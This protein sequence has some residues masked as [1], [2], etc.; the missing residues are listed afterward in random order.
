MH[1]CESLR[2]NK[3]AL[4]VADV[5]TTAQVNEKRSAGKRRPFRKTMS[6]QATLIITPVLLSLL[7]LLTPVSTSRSRR[8]GRGQH[9]HSS[10]HENRARRQTLLDNTL[11]RNPVLTSSS[12]PDTLQDA[13]KRTQPQSRDCPTQ[14]KCSLGKYV[15]CTFRSL[16][17]IPNNIAPSVRKLNIAYNRLATIKLGAFTEYSRSLRYLFL[18]SN[19]LKMVQGA[20]AN[21]TRLEILRLSHNK[22]ISVRKLLLSDMVS[23]KRLYLDNNKINFIHPEALRGLTKLSLLQ[24]DGNQLSHLHPDTFVTVKFDHYFRYSNLQRLYL[25]NNQFKVLPRSLLSGINN[26][27]QVYLHGNPW[28]C[29]C[30]LQWL[31]QW[32]RESGK[33]RCKVT[34]RGAVGPICAQCASPV[35]L[36]GQEVTSVSHDNITCSAPRF[37]GGNV[38]QSSTELFDDHPTLMEIENEE[39][40]FTLGSRPKPTMSLRLDGR[41]GSLVLMRCS[42]TSNPTTSVVQQTEEEDT[43]V[44][45]MDARMGCELEYPKEISRLEEILAPYLNSALKLTAISDRPVNAE[46]PSEYS[47]DLVNEPL[48]ALASPGSGLRISNAAVSSLDS[49]FRSPSS[50]ITIFGNLF[51]PEEAKLGLLFQTTVIHRLERG[52]KVRDFPWTMA[53]APSSF[54]M[55]AHLALES[56][57]KILKCRAMGFPRPDLSWVLPDNTMVRPNSRSGRFK[58]FGNGRLLIRQVMKTDSGVYRCLSQSVTPGGSMTEDIG[59]LFLHVVKDEG[60]VSNAQLVTLPVGSEWTSN[61][62]AEASPYA[63]VSWVAPNSRLIFGKDTRN[64]QDITGN[65]Y[66]D[67]RIKSVGIE[68]EGLYRCVAAN[69]AGRSVHSVLLQVRNVS[70]EVETVST[71]TTSTSPPT[72][73]ERLSSAITTTVA[74][75]TTSAAFKP[76]MRILLTD[77]TSS[78]S[79]DD[80]TKSTSSSTP[81]TSSEEN[82]TKTVVEDDS[83]SD[84]SSLVVPAIKVQVPHTKRSHNGNVVD[85]NEQVDESVNGTLLGDSTSN[86]LNRGEEEEEEEEEKEEEEEAENIE[87]AG[88][89]NTEETILVDYGEPLE[90][91]CPVENSTDIS[92]SF[93]PHSKPNS[94]R[95][96]DSFSEVISRIHL[97]PTMNFKQTNQLEVSRTTEHHNGTFLCRS[98]NEMHRYHVTVAAVPPRFTKPEF[99]E[100]TVEYGKSITIL[101]AAEGT[102]APEITWSWPIHD[103]MSAVVRNGDRAVPITRVYAEPDNSLHIEEI[104]PTFGVTY[105]CT[106]TNI[107]GKVEQP[108]LVQVSSKAPVIDQPEVLSTISDVGDQVLMDCAARGVPQPRH[109]WILPNGETIYATNSTTLRMHVLENGSLVINQALQEDEGPYGCIA[110]NALGEA[111]IQVSLTVIS[112]VSMSREASSTTTLSS[113]TTATTTNS[114]TM[115]SLSTTTSTMKLATIPTKTTPTST[116]TK[117]TTV[118]AASKT[119]TASTM[120]LVTIPTTT[121]PTSTTTTTTTATVNAARKSTTASSTTSTMTRPA[122]NSKTSSSPTV[123]ANTTKLPYLKT[124]RVSGYVYHDR[125]AYLRCRTLFPIIPRKPASVTA[126]TSKRRYR[127]RDVR[128]RWTLP[129]GDEAAFPSPAPSWRHRVYRNGTLRI[130]KTRLKDNGTYFCIA[131]EKK[132]G[133]QMKTVINLSIATLSPILRQHAYSTTKV[134]RGRSASADCSANGYPK[135]RIYWQAPSGKTYTAGQYATGLRVQPGGRLIVYRVNTANA[136]R[137]VC[138]ASNIAGNVSRVVKVELHGFP[139]RI[140]SARAATQWARNGHSVRLSCPVEGVPKPYLYWTLPMGKTIRLNEALFEKGT[141]RSKVA[142]LSSGTLTVNRVSNRDTGFYRC[143]V[144]NRMGSD[145]KAVSL[146]VFY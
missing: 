68:N 134:R 49:F 87:D 129:T 71:S 130:I 37:V 39:T 4:L 141:T 19:E 23:L 67:I 46:A 42:V 113:T 21:L 29:S 52:E 2:A 121:T 98:K 75:T 84:D 106:A 64:Y 105:L 53:G 73:E 142:V 81:T 77:P 95:N 70:D 69:R 124:F 57:T 137:Y 91:S 89:I 82:L 144:R 102:P 80:K 27:Q 44:G 128:V 47:V 63:T 97:M 11:R 60:D 66:A 8:I 93:L 123:V 85:S 13:R 26:L 109:M 25:S 48:S 94:R 117:T 138:T 135:P 24:L 7:L 51:R 50:T 41:A 139:P 122:I 111:S 101:C 30:Q 119:T 34:L 127:H 10:H 74:S 83:D 65:K 112:D 5:M 61:C 132:T 114:S 3:K 120:K 31:H 14:C 96:R 36:K 35:F 88:S 131:T 92:W 33:N 32:M 76:T 16:T 79:V 17:E 99:S 107:A 100:I 62:T 118:K 104:T 12:I 145:M 108:V 28:E 116:T 90:I 126:S 1:L 43:Y 20:F 72:E 56:S 133:R 38:N 59:S 86:E 58:V 22:L 136:G 15:Q 18:Q 146:K 140:R 55:D 9:H 6:S 103:V 54:R 143:H 78:V 40:L 125:P 115:P 110:T 45:N